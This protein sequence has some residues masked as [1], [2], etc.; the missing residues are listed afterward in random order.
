[1]NIKT[2]YPPRPARRGGTLGAVPWRAEVVS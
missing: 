2:V 1:M